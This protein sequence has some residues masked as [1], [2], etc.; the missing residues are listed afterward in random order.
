V[1]GDGFA[2]FCMARI[3]RQIERSSGLPPPAMES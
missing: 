3:V 2:A 1:D